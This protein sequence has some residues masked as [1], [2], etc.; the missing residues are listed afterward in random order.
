VT[1]TRRLSKCKGCPSNGIHSAGTSTIQA[2]PASAPPQQ[3]DKQKQHLHSAAKLLNMQSTLRASASVRSA[4]S[5]T[6]R[7]ASRA[8]RVSALPSRRRTAVIVKAELQGPRGGGLVDGIDAMLKVGTAHCW[9][10]RFA[11]EICWPFQRVCA[12]RPVQLH[13][14]CCQRVASVFGPRFGAHGLTPATTSCLVAK[15]A[16]PCAV[17]F[18][19]V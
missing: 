18:A 12:L 3:L 1:V 9:A 19:E 13:H 4:S 11:L 16:S 5:S 10:P 2:H 8:V 15:S 14:L 17:V 7:R 6:A